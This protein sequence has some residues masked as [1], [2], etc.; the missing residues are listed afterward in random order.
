MLKALILKKRLDEK[1]AAL[2][3]LREKADG[4]ETREAELATD[5]ESAQ[6]EEERSAVEA[7]V[8]AFTAEKRDTEEQAQ[9]LETEIG[10]LEADL[11]AAEEEQAQTRSK[12]PAQEQRTEE[13]T[14][15]SIRGLTDELI[16]REAPAAFLTRVREAIKEKRAISNVG[17]VVPTEFLGII[18]ENVEKWSKLYSRVNL[19]RLSG[20]GRLVIMGTVPQ[21]VWT[22]CCGKLNEIDLTFADAEVDCHKLGAFVPVC[23]A[24]LED[25]DIDLAA[26]ILDALGQSIGLALDQAILFGTGIKMPL[27]VYTRLAQT[28]MPADYPATARP[29]ENLTGHMIQIESTVTGVDLFKRIVIASGQAKGK[30]SR[31]EK[32]W[33]MNE[34]TYTYL[35]AQAMDVTAGGAIVSG[36]NASMPV[37]GGSILVFP[38]ISDG[39]IIG[40]FFD[41]YLL[42][43]RKGVRLAS[44]EHARFLDDTTVFKATARYDGMPVIAEA[45]VEISIDG[46]YVTIPTFPEDTAN[47]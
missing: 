45:F 44:S 40:G 2:A 31:G 22:E 7:A 30:Y 35:M 25:A 32:V 47:A 41:C 24:S 36:V 23:N 38:F 5:I 39:T 46:S 14:A 33:C 15:M 12:K 20:D 37:A 19:K 42:G 4:F 34:W 29:W 10:Q 6:T 8:D 18:R 13:K 11:E 1:K 28:E 17:L 26:E 9:E 27:G 43:E 16:K 3:A 21:A